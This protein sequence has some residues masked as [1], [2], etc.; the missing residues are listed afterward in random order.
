MTQKQMRQKADW[1]WDRY[2]RQSNAVVDEEGRKIYIGYF[3][4]TGLPPGYNV[5]RIRFI[6]KHPVKAMK[7]IVDSGK[8]PEEFNGAQI[9]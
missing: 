5:I 1:G 4:T 6:A 9:N 7:M 3:R 8:D 2:T